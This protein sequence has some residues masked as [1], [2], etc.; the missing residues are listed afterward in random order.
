MTEDGR[1]RT[2][3]RRLLAFVNPTQSAA[4]LAKLICIGQALKAFARTAAFAAIRP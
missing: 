1:Q 4:R 2:D 3:N